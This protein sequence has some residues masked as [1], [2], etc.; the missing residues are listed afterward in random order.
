MK[1]KKTKIGTASFALL[2][3]A[4]AS[5]NGGGSSDGGVD[6]GGR[7][8]GASTGGSAGSGRGGGSATG[9]SGGGG[10]SATGGSSGGGGGSATGGGAGATTTR[11]FFTPALAQAQECLADAQ[12]PSGA[13]CFKLTAELGL[14]G[15]QQHTPVQP[16][17]CISTPAPCGC[18]GGPTCM[19][20]ETCTTPGAGD[21]N[22]CAPNPCAAA[23]DCPAGSACVP[24]RM[25][26]TN[27]CIA[28]R[29]ARDSDCTDG[30][31]GRCAALI[32]V[33]FQSGATSLTDVRCVYRDGGGT[34]CQGT[35]VRDLGNDY[36]ACPMLAR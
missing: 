9:G 22:V 27:R 21:P 31:E 1:A 6:S 14:C 8:G 25:I 32:S 26:R 33:T 15:T 18:S 28:T 17:G 20:G 30:P 24:S 3:I 23:T 4:L 19:A 2:S 13:R 16:G 11:V 7:G 29:C 35:Q 10:G 34:R 5:C 12:C 36:Y